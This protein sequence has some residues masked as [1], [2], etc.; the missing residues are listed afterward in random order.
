MLK[1]T[2]IL[3]VVTAGLCSGSFAQP[4]DLPTAPQGFFWKR[5]D[6]IK[7]AFLMPDGWYFKRETQKNTLA[8]F[9][10]QEN[11]DKQGLLETG[12]TVNLIRRLTAVSAHTYARQFISKFTSENQVIHTWELGTGV[13]KGYGCQIKIPASK[14]RPVIMMHN[15]AIAN[16]RTNTLYLLMFESPENKWPTAWEKGKVIMDVFALDDEI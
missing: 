7:A 10:T 15:L 4:A 9:I 5:I 6:E 8:Y 1:S 2:A 3:I 11:I 12:L 14:D 16:I 13:L